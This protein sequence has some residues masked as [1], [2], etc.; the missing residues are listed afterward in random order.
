MEVPRVTKP[1]LAA[2]LTT[3]AVKPETVSRLTSRDRATRDAA[4]V[5]LAWQVRWPSLLSSCAMLLATYALARNLGLG[6]HVA[7]ASAAVCGSTILFLRFARAATTDVQLALWVTVANAFLALAFFRGRLW[8]GSLGA[9]A[10]LGL[11]FMSKGPVAFVQTLVP[12]AL[13]LAWRRWAMAATP[14]P[15]TPGEGR[16][17]G[18][19]SI[20]NQKSKIE[21]SK[22]PHPN[23]L[24][25]YRERE[26]FA[27]CLAPFAGLAVMLLVGLPWYG[28]VLHRYPDIVSAWRS[29]VTRVGAT[30]LPPDPWYVYLVLVPWTAPWIPWF[31]AGVWVAALGI[32]RGAR[33]EE[34]AAARRWR[35]GTVG[36]LLLVVVPVVVMS[37]FKDKN[38]RY[39]LPMLPPAAILAA[40][41]AAG[42][43]QS[44]D[45]AS[46]RD[47]AGKVVETIHWVTL[48]AL[49][50]GGP[51]MIQAQ[52]KIDPADPWTSF[53]SV[54]AM[55]LA[56]FVTVTAAWAFRVYRGG[57]GA[58]VAT[59]VGAAAAVL[60]LLQF[61]AMHL[62]APQ[63]T[64]DLRQ[65]A[66]AV[67][68]RYPD[69]QVY[70]YEPDGRTR[71]RID[72]PI[73]LGRVTRAVTAEELPAASA[74]RPQVVVVLSRYS[75]RAP[76]FPPEWKELDRGGGR[77]GGWTAY[78]LPAAEKP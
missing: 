2:W 32:G 26:Q 41:A 30:D 59:S 38:E 12:F 45:P 35:E 67:W 62:Y 56:G 24:P 74:T 49:A 78:V 60:L 40:R 48:T 4:F 50:G 61:P 71:V 6:P 63:S 23:P 37:L 7:L 39:L 27:R 29:E 76:Q 58:V 55:A 68:E 20:A 42:W 15:G 69:A 70:Q 9:G 65:L 64:S 14:S 52:R 54:G 57:G 34:S 28:F 5:E 46:R 75:G 10:A 25:E 53:A 72:L 19:S 36:A 3:A 66:D 17:E 21:N 44:R 77:K 18:A 31:I 11:A 22:S 47:L 1:P 33:S 51:F 13:L 8:V 43:W 73:Y 16:G